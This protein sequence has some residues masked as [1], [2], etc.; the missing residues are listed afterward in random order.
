MEQR[1]NYSQLVAELC[2]SFTP[3]KLLIEYSSL[4]HDKKQGIMETVDQ[5]AQDLHSL[6]NKI[7]PT[8]QQGTRESETLGQTVLVNQFVPGPL[9][10]IVKV[11]KVVLDNYLLKL[12]LKKLSCNILVLPVQRFQGV[13]PRYICLVI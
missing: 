5:Y 4:F 7:Y 3:V 11:S 10:E 9:P 1:S 6:F 8:V 13:R 2:K 12:G